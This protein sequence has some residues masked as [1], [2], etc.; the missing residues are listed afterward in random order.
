LVSGGAQPQFTPGYGIP[1]KFR[2][3]EGILGAEALVWRAASG[4]L[5]R[6]CEWRILNAGITRWR[7][8]LYGR[9]GTARSER[10]TSFLYE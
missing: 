3:G 10:E 8:R 4:T 2:I 7:E 6:E 1:S 5:T 9:A